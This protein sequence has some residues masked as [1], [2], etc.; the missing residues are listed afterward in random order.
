MQ[1]G[2]AELSAPTPTPVPAAAG[3]AASSATAPVA[4]THRNAALYRQQFKELV[5]TLQT[6]GVPLLV[7][8]F[9]SYDRLTPGSTC[10]HPE[11]AVLQQA[12][13]E[14][15]GVPFLDLFT[16]FSRYAAE[17]L[18]LLNRGPGLAPIRS[19]CV[20]AEVVYPGNAHLAREGNQVT[21]AALEEALK[22]ISWGPSS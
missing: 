15:G 12:L 22:S 17:D 19:T 18:Y 4:E 21:A 13:A 2:A 1:R 7:I 8:S 3:G 20:P 10:P 11:Q 5:Q 14:N 6:A 9:P 16:A